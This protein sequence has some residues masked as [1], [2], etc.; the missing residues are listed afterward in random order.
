M[1]LSLT[2]LDLVS[3]CEL[4]EARAQM[5]DGLP[6]VAARVEVEEA[7]PDWLGDWR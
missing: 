6:P 2:L 4:T 1:P 7:M 5:L 3:S